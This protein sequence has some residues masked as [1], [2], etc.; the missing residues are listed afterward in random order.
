MAMADTVEGSRG[1]K[2][3]LSDPWPMSRMRVRPPASTMYED[4]G[5]PRDS[6]QAAAEPRT[7]RVRPTRGVVR[8]SCSRYDSFGVTPRPGRPVRQSSSHAGSVADAV[9]Q[10]DAHCADSRRAPEARA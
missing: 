9:R 1:P 4:D 10:H 6:D 8:S 2:A 7:V 3:E 5:R